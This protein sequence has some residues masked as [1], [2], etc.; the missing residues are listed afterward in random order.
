MARKK[1]GGEGAKGEVQRK[2][3]GGYYIRKELDAEL[4]EKERMGRNY[5]KA[6]EGEKQVCCF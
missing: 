1:Q 2:K 6:G 4:P 5:I 3:R